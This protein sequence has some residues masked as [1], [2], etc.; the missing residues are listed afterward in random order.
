MRQAAKRRPAIPA[1]PNAIGLARIAV[2]PQFTQPFFHSLCRPPLQIKQPGLIT[3]LFR[4][5]GQALDVAQAQKTV[6]PL[7]ERRLVFL[8]AHLVNTFADN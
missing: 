2:A 1:L 3:A 5:D 6:A 4:L 8:H 7:R